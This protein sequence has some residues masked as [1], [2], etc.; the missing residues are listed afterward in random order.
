[1]GFENQKVYF[2][3]QFKTKRLESVWKL[4]LV[5]KLEI[6]MSQTE[7]WEMLLLMPR[8]EIAGRD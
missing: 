6:Y 2:P 3:V 7:G 5:F 8:S 4:Y 1:M